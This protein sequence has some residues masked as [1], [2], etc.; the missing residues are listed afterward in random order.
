MEKDS[1]LLSLFLDY[2]KISAI[3]FVKMKLFERFVLDSV[4]CTQGQ[5]YWLLI[6]WLQ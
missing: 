3:L 1:K 5:K 6:Y 2:W 4:R